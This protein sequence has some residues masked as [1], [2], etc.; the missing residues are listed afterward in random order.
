[1][2][3]LLAKAAGRLYAGE[4]RGRAELQAE[5]SGLIAS[6]RGRMATTAQKCSSPGIL[7]RVL[8]SVLSKL[9]V[10]SANPVKY[11]DMCGTEVGRSEY[12]Q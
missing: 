7:I 2:V 5:F 11:T 8:L 10:S 9:D 4:F 12:Q 1:M 3:G 6:S